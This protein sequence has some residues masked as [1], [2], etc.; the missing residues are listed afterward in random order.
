MIP[1]PAHTTT[2]EDIRKARFLMRPIPGA[3]MA[4]DLK[5]AAEELRVGYGE[6]DQGLWFWIGE[7]L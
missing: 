7:P 3:R 5:E 1:S 4:L 6:L 2:L